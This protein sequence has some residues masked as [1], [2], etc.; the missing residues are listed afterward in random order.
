SFGWRASFLLFGIIPLLWLWP[1][2]SLTREMHRRSPPASE[3]R[4][5]SYF[6]I[7]VKRAIWGTTLG[8]F[9]TN[10]TLYFVLSWLPLYLVKSRGFSL[11]EMTKVGALI[12]LTYGVCRILSGFL[13]HRC[14]ALVACTN[15][16]R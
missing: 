12:Y 14:I 5:P 2:L 16:W 1:W 9:A 3:E 6:A 4:A 11:V 13:H 10:Y 15:V 7:V 8:H